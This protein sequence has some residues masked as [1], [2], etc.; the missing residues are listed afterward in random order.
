MKSLIVLFSLFLVTLAQAKYDN[1]WYQA[2]Y[3]PGEYPAGFSV[4]K[5]G[6]KIPARTDT[7]KDLAPSLQCPVEFK[8]V[9]HVWN[10]NKRADFTTFSKIVPLTVKE[11]FEFVTYGDENQEIRIPL[12]KGDLIEYLVYGAE[13]WF[14]VRINGKE[15]GA[16]QDLFSKVNEVDQSAFQD[17]QW[18]VLNC[19]GQT[20][21]VL[22]ADL[23][24][25]D[26]D[27]NE[28]FRDGLA[29]WYL[30]FR[31]YGTVTDLTDK[32]LKKSK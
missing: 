25:V 1:T 17:D 3:W 9:Y 13:G 23:Y 24:T 18:L 2:D 5:K 20:A 22:F 7:D 8:A 6:V 28:K 10:E 14:T 19:G 26:A 16:D 30:G 15:Y 12:Q 11:D 29:S 21:Y 32:D 4:V 27:G 31:D